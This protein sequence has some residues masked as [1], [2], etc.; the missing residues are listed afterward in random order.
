M[1]SEA[2]LGGFADTDL[3]K[4]A[5][6]FVEKSTGWVIDSFLSIAGPWRPGCLGPH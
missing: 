2:V 1:A 4:A 6:C 5:V 3:G